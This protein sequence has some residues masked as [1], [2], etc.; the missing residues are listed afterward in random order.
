MN[1]RSRAGGES[2][3]P[4]YVTASERR[5]VKKVIVCLSSTHWH[6]LWQR[7]QQIMTRLSYDY[8][9][10]FVDP[11]SPL[12]NEPVRSDNH[13]NYL[14]RQLISIN[15]GLKVLSPWETG[16][17]GLY[18]FKV[19]EQ[20]KK[21]LAHLRWVHPPLLWIYNLPGVSLIGQFGELGVLYDCVDSFDSFSWAHP[22]TKRWE[23]ELLGKADVVLA[24]ARTLFEEKRQQ[25]PE[26]YLLL[27]AADFAHFSKAEHF[28]TNDPPDLKPIG[29]PRLGFTG[30]AYEWLDFELLKNLAAAHPT[31]NLV[32]IGPQQHGL[33][34]PQQKNLHW[35]GPRDYKALPWYIHGLD[36]MMIPFIRNRTTEHANPIKLWEYL[37]AGKPVVSAHLPE[38]PEI[39]GVVWQGETFE[40]F[41]A[42]CVAI[43]KRIAITEKKNEIV[44]RARAV[45]QRNSW[46][47]RCQ[48]IRKI[49]RQRFGI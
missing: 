2:D 42:S 12:Q 8:N 21:A 33:S 37:A 40:D 25:N 14:T 43:L 48:T 28:G 26:T 19:L 49:L 22:D 11:P 15:S 31:W 44:S 5:S 3:L 13:Y 41:E 18:S 32:M 27:N 7:P 16:N 46:D 4:I 36:L 30:A 24:S 23:G 34:L 35:L 9:I 10:L 6:F 39:K 38:V 47:E 20:I 1:L 45:A 17:G 29:H